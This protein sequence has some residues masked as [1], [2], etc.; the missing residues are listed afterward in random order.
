[1]TFV[2]DA[3]LTYAGSLLWVVCFA[4]LLLSAAGLSLFWAF[5][6]ARSAEAAR[7]PS[8][9]PLRKGPITLHGRVQT[10]DGFPAIKLRIEQVGGER[11]DKYGRI[12]MSVWKE[13][14]RKLTTQPFELVLEGGL[15]VHVE[16]GPSPFLID[17]L[18]ER[19]GTVSTRIAQAELSHG[20]RVCIEGV[21][22]QKHLHNGEGDYRGTHATWVLRPPSTGPML[23]STAF[24]AVH[25][26]RRARV[27]RVTGLVCIA[28]LI[29][30]FLAAGSYVPLL[31]AGA[32]TE[33]Q[34]TA[35]RQDA[36]C[37]RSA[38]PRLLDMR[39]ASDE[40]LSAQVSLSTYEQL[41]DGDRVPLLRVPSRP[42]MHQLGTRATLPKH[43]PLWMLLLALIPLVVGWLMH[44]WNIGWFTQKRVTH[45]Q[46]A[47]YHH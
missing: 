12:V 11:R 20:E 29:L 4:M 23:L 38:C 7:T 16:P 14:S 6:H 19:G 13:A 3:H 18:V 39:T 44:A 35:H 15:R 31:L 2:D 8:K 32:P 26:T 1:M 37:G 28:T 34:V 5:H 43:A 46:D 22:T 47:G 21:L 25:H 42:S 36:W 9:V 40:V 27:W 41:E 24:L 10:S 33:A 17:D 45:I 30:S